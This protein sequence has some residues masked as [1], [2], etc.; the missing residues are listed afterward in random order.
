LEG[1]AADLALDDQFMNAQYRAHQI[2]RLHFNEG[3]LRESPGF[4]SLWEG[5]YPAEKLWHRRRNYPFGWVNRT[6]RL[7]GI[8]DTKHSLA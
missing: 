3:M 2:V 7:N 4:I 8:S 6:M 1:Q 5:D